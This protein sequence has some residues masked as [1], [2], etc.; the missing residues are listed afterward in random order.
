MKATDLS[1]DDLEECIDGSTNID[2]IRE[3]LEKEFT[4][5]DDGRVIPGNFADWFAYAIEGFI[6][7]D[8]DEDPAAWEDAWENNYDWGIDIAIAINEKLQELK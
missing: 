1:D 6:D 8:E 5:A 4:M 2:M 7:V 3:I